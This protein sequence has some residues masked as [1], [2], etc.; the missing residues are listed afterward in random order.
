MNDGTLPYDFSHP[1]IEKLNDGSKN[2]NSTISNQ[3]IQDEQKKSQIEY[4]KEKL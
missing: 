4:I 1:Q 3:D 2:N